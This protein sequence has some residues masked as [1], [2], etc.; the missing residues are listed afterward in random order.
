MI[1]QPWILLTL[2]I[3]ALLLVLWQSE[4]SITARECFLKVMFLL[5]VGLCRCLF[6]LERNDVGDVG[7]IAVGTALQHLSALTTSLGF[8]STLYIVHNIWSLCGIRDDT[9]CA[10]LGCIIVRLSNLS[11]N[12]IGCDGITGLAGALQSLHHVP[13]LACLEY[14]KVQA[15]GVMGWST[16]SL[17]GVICLL[18]TFFT[19]AGWWQTV[20]RRQAPSSLRALSRVWT[21]HAA[22]GGQMERWV[23][24]SDVAFVMVMMEATG[25]PSDGPTSSLHHDSRSGRSSSQGPICFRMCVRLKQPRVLPFA[26]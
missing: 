11:Y 4:L 24:Q 12:R 23:F 8:V 6:R 17:F 10:C 2:A 7:C 13:K 5:F 1:V 25:L 21:D 18:V 22:V 26:G 14:V 15:N 9:F 3:L 16:L 20:L 19:A